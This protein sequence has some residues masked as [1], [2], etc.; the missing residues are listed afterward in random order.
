MKLYKRLGAFAS[1]LQM[2][3]F[4]SLDYL[5]VPAWDVDAT[6]M[7]MIMHTDPKSRALV[8]RLVYSSLCRRGRCKC[9]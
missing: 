8:S 5:Y 7:C 6:E 9:S 1:T 3:M 2:A 4:L